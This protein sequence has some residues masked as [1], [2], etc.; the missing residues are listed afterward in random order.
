MITL[1]G[2]DFYVNIIVKMNIIYI[3]LALYS[4]SAKNIILTCFLKRMKSHQ[5]HFLEEEK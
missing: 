2:V 5:H 1:S 3:D 4:V